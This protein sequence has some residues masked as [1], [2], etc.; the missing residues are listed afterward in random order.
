MWGF[1]SRLWPFSS[2][3]KD[4]YS[5]AVMAHTFDPSTWEAKAGR[6]LSLRPAWSTEWVPGQPGLHR[7]T[8]S[9]K[10]KQNKTK[11][12][13]HNLYI[14]NKPQLAQELVKYLPSMLLESTSL[15]ITPSY[16]LLCFI[17]A[18]LPQGHIFMTHLTHGGF[19]STSF[20]FC[21]LLQIPRPWNPKSHLHLFCPAIYWLSTSL[22]T[23]QK[24]RGGKVT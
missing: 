13:T 19:S 23:N 21:G 17:G 5:W 11:Q 18:A 10:T 22:F 8:L 1:L 9:W 15:S 12:D 24:Y 6:F 7:E 14:Y 16:L 4:A 20:T 2:W 3:I